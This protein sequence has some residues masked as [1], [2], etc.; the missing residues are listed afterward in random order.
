MKIKFLISG[1]LI[2]FLSGCAVR[3]FEMPPPKAYRGP[4]VRIGILTGKTAI[5]F[6]PMGRCQIMAGG[7][8][9]TQGDSGETWIVGVKDSNPAKVV[10]RLVAG[11]MS[12]RDRAREKAREV[13]ALGFKT[14]I[15]PIG[16]SSFALQTGVFPTLY[17]RV[18]LADTFETDSSARAFREQL[19]NRLDTF[20]VREIATPSSGQLVLKNVTKNVQYETAE[21]IQISGATI[22][23]RDIPVGTGFHWEKLENRAYP[24]VL[25]FTLDVHGKLSAI[26][27]IPLELY[28]EG[29][30]PYEMPNGFPESALRAQAV[31]IRSKA[32]ALK[33]LVHSGDPFDF[34]GEVHC[35][36]YGGLDR[37]NFLVSRAV[38]KTEGQ[39]LFKDGRIL[40]AVYSAVCGGHTDNVEEIWN[41]SPKVHL[42][43]RV[44]GPSSLKR[45]EP[46]DQEENVRKWILE[47]PHAYCNTIN[48]DWPSAFAYTKKY[49]RWEVRLSQDEL[50]TQLEKST[51]KS[52]GAILN[53]VP[54]K[55]TQSG[56][57]TQLKIV[58]TER[59]TVL[60]G[61]LTI[62]K[63]LYSS[64]LW[65]SCFIV[66]PQNPLEGIP[67]TFILKG[68]GWGHGVG[69]CQTGAGVLAF[70][71]KSYK[72]ILKFY[73]PN[74]ELKK[75][76]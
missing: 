66:I 54:L 71:G 61:E 47:S 15:K 39:V 25:E 10:F 35:Q 58:G 14:L 11:S 44:D 30:L 63:A 20:I 75:L 34:C 6:S 21:S 17:Y 24:P 69:M 43:A 28:V 27:I 1:S 40:D 26:N 8:L 33:G 49:F 57:I 68:A 9:L 42:K 12:S 59:D 76:Y 31:C 56:R 45:Y 5:E 51:G 74:A 19:K 64:T 2:L 16:M 23:I 52:L 36:V 13:E 50:R 7:I 67:Q 46:L 70:C 3:R 18:Y 22:Q 4:E 29:V 53:M 38:R 65:S 32:L 55:R 41:T 37:R 48:G 73:F 62:R 60:E 72:T